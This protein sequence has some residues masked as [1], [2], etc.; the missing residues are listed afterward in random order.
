MPQMQELGQIVTIA[1]L[2]TE[3]SLLLKVLQITPAIDNQVDVDSGVHD[4]IDHSI[5]FE[6]DFSIFFDA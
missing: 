1:N 3:Q 2:L 5:G 4:A 6:I